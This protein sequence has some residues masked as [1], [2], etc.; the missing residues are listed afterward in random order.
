MTKTE[1]AALKISVYR[2][3]Q[4]TDRDA[5]AE[6]HKGIRHYANAGPVDTTEEYRAE[7]LAHIAHLDR[8]V[9]LWKPNLSSGN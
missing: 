7:K 6:L 1:F 3:A 2:A 9:R 4:K 8:C 5:L